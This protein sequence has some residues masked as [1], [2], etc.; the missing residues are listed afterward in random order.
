MDLIIL[1]SDLVP[2]CCCCTGCFCW[3]SWQVGKAA[4]QAVRGIQVRPP[5]EHG[6]ACK[7]LDSYH[8]ERYSHPDDSDYGYSVRVHGGRGEFCTLRQCFNFMDPYQRG[9]VN[10]R[11]ALRELLVHLGAAHSSRMTTRSHDWSEKDVRK[12]WKGIDSDGNGYISFPEF[13]EWASLADP[14]LCLPQP[15]GIIGE[16][17]RSGQYALPCTAEGC[18]CQ[19]FWAAVEGDRFCSV[20]GCGHK[21]G[22]HAASR[23]DQVLAV[24]PPGWTCQVSSFDAQDLI[25]QRELVPCDASQVA[26]LQQLVDASVRRVWTR[27]R[28]KTNKVPL[29]YKVVRAERNENIRLWLKYVMK[30]TLILEALTH[31]VA[32]GSMPPVDCFQML[33]SESAGTLPIFERARADAGVNEW[34]L[35]H[36]ASSAG[37]KSIAEQEF[38]QLHAGS[39]TGT[40]YGAGTYLSDSCTKADEYAREATEGEDAGLCCLLLCRVMGGR[41]FYTEEREPDGQALVRHVLEGSYDSVLGDRE[42]CRGTFK[43][44]VVYESSQAYPEYLVY[45][46]RILEEAVEKA[47]E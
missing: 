11:A 1:C 4:L 12:V 29:G 21:R 18:S 25:G 36:G 28:G 45:Y 20:E 23:R 35:W 37:I 27:D 47:V 7:N 42:K 44:I 2:V 17:G 13:V 24:L 41:V 22:Q 34:Y 32:S 15:V 19:G 26:Q 40:L 31:Q 30:K 6:L 43:E 14:K 10:E 33:T 38:K 3:T 16:K 8:L 5:C 39:N 46:R 9:Y